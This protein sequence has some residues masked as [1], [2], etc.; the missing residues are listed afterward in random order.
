MRQRREIAPFTE[1]EWLK[2]ILKDL[3]P[4]PKR[5]DEYTAKELIDLARKGGRKVSEISL[6]RRLRNCIASGTWLRRRLGKEYVYRQLVPP[7]KRKP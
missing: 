7:G 1:E 4:P 2:E 5:A 3:A 6:N